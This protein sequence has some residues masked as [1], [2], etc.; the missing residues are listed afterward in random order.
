MDDGLRMEK[1][2]AS[3]FDVMMQAS[4]VKPDR[5]G[6]IVVLQRRRLNA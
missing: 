1:L 2:C 4:A 5:F 3:R 6:V